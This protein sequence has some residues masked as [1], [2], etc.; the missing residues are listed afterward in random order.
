MSDRSL[1][2]ASYARAD[3]GG[4]QLSAAIQRT[5][6]SFD[7]DGNGS[8]DM[9][10]LRAAFASMVRVTHRWRRARSLFTLS[11]ANARYRRRNATPRRLLLALRA[12]FASIWSASLTDGAVLTRWCCHSLV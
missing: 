9:G 5:F 3:G 11:L 7:T 1:P 4:G 8:L 10:E 12:A 2:T 6:R